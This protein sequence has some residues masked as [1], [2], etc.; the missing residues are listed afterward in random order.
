MA[1]MAAS[2]RAGHERIPMEVDLRCLYFR[3]I[4]NRQRRRRKRPQIGTNEPRGY[5]ELYSP[6]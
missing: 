2:A 1:V 6:L 3:D 4:D 5:V